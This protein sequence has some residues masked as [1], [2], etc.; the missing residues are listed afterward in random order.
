M[1]KAAL[2]ADLSPQILSEILGHHSYESIM[3]VK[4]VDFGKIMLH[5]EQVG[6][7]KKKPQGELL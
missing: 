7:A 1:N 6:D 2:K 3:E 4:G 5:I